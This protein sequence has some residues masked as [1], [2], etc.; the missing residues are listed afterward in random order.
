M[1][2]TADKRQT[3]FDIYSSNLNLL[4]DSGFIKGYSKNC[5]VCPLCLKEHSSP[6]SENPLTLE[7]APP[8]SLG[9]S[10][11]I[12][13]CKSCNNTCGYKIDFHLTERLRELD[14]LEMKPGTETKVKVKIGNEVFQGTLIAEEDGTFKMFHSR[15]NNN[16]DK[17][18][19]QM[20]QPMKGEV[21]KA[22]YLKSRV[23]PENL[24]YALLKT[25]YLLAFEKFGYGFILDKC[26]DIVREQ[27]LHPEQ[28]I[29]PEGFWYVPSY[30][31]E[32][33]GSYFICD[34]GLE[35]ILSLF[36][37]NTNKTERMF[38]TILPL[39][40]H[41]IEEVIARINEK[42]EKNSGTS[43]TLYPEKNQS[44]YLAN[45]ENLKAMYDWFRERSKVS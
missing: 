23:V 19:E 7:D 45:T 28:R 3:I 30:P 37:L 5:Y 25:G 31:K 14:S 20:E 24:E 40:I 13:T 43:L 44:D 18:D 41:G 9:G 27:I 11:N 36:V 17:L 42:I 21:I 33:S 10:A 12:L 1:S 16:P 26:F 22:E 15:K 29:Y 32:K 38:G 39:P 6:D 34:K 4:L 35:G 8:K 2:K